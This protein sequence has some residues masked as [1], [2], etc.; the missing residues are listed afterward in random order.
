MSVNGMWM[1]NNECT[2]SPE[3]ENEI[4]PCVECIVK[5]VCLLDHTECDKYKDYCLKQ[6]SLQNQN[7]ADIPCISCSDHKK[8]LEIIEKVKSK[9]NIQH[10]VD[11]Y[12]V[13][14]L[15][16]EIEIFIDILR[17]LQKGCGKLKEYF[18]YDIVSR[19]NLMKLPVSRN[20]IMQEEE[21]DKRNLNLFHFF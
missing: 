14:E 11:E 19:D 15:D 4:C 1:I 12:C 18:P 13:D 8:C 21:W 7:D 10:E 2:L 17:E 16:V 6:V 5:M 20:I 9:T 3:Y